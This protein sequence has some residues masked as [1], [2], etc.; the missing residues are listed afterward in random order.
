MA[1]LVE[2]IEIVPEM[3]VLD[4]GHGTNTKIADFF[5][6]KGCKFWGYGQALGKYVH[7]IFRK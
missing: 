2:N 3:T 7:E 4:V 1:W 5:L 6:S